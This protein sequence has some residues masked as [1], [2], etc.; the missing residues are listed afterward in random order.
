MFDKSLNLMRP[1]KKHHHEQTKMHM[2]LLPVPTLIF[3]T[4][5]T[6]LLSLVDKHRS[7]TVYKFEDTK[8]VIRSQ[9]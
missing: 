9:N 4:Y 3:G 1:I 5:P 6:V 8:G 2:I 7:Y